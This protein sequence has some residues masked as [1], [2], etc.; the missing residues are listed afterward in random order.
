MVPDWFSFAGF[1]IQT[2]ATVFAVVVGV[3]HLER[4]ITR[5]E[6]KVD[7]LWHRFVERE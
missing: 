7:A 6:T 5:V 1:L 4:R 2:A 3:I